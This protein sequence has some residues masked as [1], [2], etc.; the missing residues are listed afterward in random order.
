VTKG[1]P[2]ASA[3]TCADGQRCDAGRCLW[4][5][6]VGE[7]GD[8]CTFEQY[9]LTGLCAGTNEKTICTQS[10]V[11]GVTDGCPDASYECLEQSAGRGVCWPKGAEEGN[12]L[13]CSSAGTGAPPF[14]LGLFGLGLILRKRRR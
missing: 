7:F 8:D 3:E 4:D 5:P 9:C 14:L 1:A 12:C 11:P 6:P 13:G 10:C 2:C